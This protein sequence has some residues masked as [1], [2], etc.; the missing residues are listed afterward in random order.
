MKVSRW[1]DSIL[2]GN[3]DSRLDVMLPLNKVFN[4]RRTS[5]ASHTSTSINEKAKGGKRCENCDC[6]ILVL[7]FKSRAVIGLVD[8]R[9]EDYA[10]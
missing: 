9:T 5:R 7:S 6:G 8:R 1:L 3:L 2:V 4:T 10:R